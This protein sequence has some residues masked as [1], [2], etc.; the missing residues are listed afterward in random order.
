METRK[1][2][3]F[4]LSALESEVPSFEADVLRSIV[5]GGT[6]TYSNPYSWDQVESM[7]DAGTWSGGYVM[8]EGA[9]YLLGNMLPEGH[10]IWNVWW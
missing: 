3:R 7:I 8:H 10:G 4:R 9:P 1:L 5:G 2:S 6:G